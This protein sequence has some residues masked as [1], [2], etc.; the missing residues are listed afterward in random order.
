MA[1][2]SFLV[3][4][5]GAT[6]LLLFAVRMVRTGIERSFGAG[7]KRVLT[8]NKSLWGSSLA[9][10]SLAVVLQSSAAVALLASGFIASGILAFPA[11]LAIV[12][13]GDLGSALVI[14]ILSFKL[15]WLVPLLLAAGGWL[16]VKTEQKRWRQ[17]GRVLMGVALILISLRFL[18]EAM[19]PIS[20][21]AF[22]PALAEYLARD[23]AT[24]FIIGAV[25]AFVMHSS[26]AAVLMCV[27]LVQIGAIPFDAGLSLALGAN[28]GSALIPVWLTRGMSAEA[29][30]VPLANLLLRGGWALAA[31]V[32]VNWFDVAP[33]KGSANPGQAL[34]YGHLAFNATLL[35]AALPF[36]SQVQKLMVLLLPASAAGQAASP[37]SRPASALDRNALQD[38]NLAIGSLKRELLRMVEMTE[39]MFLPILDLFD[40]EDPATLKAVCEL[41]QEVNQ[42]LAG[43]RHYVAQIPVSAFDASGAKSVQGLM[44]YAIRVESA[45]DVI[46]KVLA[47]R[48]EEK[49]QSAARFS[50]E[51]WKELVRMHE[52]T[53]ANLRLACNVLMSDDLES[54]RLLVIEKTEIKRAERDSR[55]NHLRRLQDGRSD[56]FDTS[57]IHLETVRALR[58]FNGHISAI[59]YPI[60]HEYGQLLETRLIMDMDSR[61]RQNA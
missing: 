7:F 13:G 11:G 25:L 56:S 59:A 36:C 17:A 5:A 46:C 35:A 48:I 57:N 33:L 42:T 38:P 10:L 43:I 8:E 20:G 41:D 49:H 60:L 53:T 2:L 37:L 26:V 1:I 16:F 15:D 34:I 24:A 40:K 45:G 54:A 12:L 28:F 58:D 6:M 30:R 47:R 52:A 9:G 14:Q 51:G 21:S 27:T 39:R 4:L 32:F 23:F 22:L 61:S 19:A 18:R 55:K 29:R 31:L 3:H 44:E 50:E